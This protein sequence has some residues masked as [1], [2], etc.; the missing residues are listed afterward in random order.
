MLALRGRI[1]DRRE[2]T[3][4]FARQRLRRAAQHESLSVLL[5]G[6]DQRELSGR[7]R[8][9]VDFQHHVGL[10]LPLPDRL[11][12]R[13]QRQR[14]RSENDDATRRRRGLVSQRRHDGSKSCRRRSLRSARRDTDLDPH[15]ENTAVATHDRP[16]TEP[17]VIQRDTLIGGVLS[18]VESVQGAVH[19]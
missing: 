12:I 7:Q 2:Q 18:L 11:Q 8:I 17:Q 13:T 15:A 9:S 4:R 10:A 1:D 6:F 5:G 19:T 14:C 16:P 3:V